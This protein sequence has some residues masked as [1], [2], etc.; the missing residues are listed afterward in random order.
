MRGKRQQRDHGGLQSSHRFR[1]QPG[2]WRGARTM[3]GSNAV[4]TQD[5]ELQLRRSWRG[6]AQGPVN[7]H[8][9]HRCLGS[10]PGLV[11]LVRLAHPGG[12]AP[13]SIREMPPRF[14]ASAQSSWCSAGISGHLRLQLITTSSSVWTRAWCSLVRL[15]RCGAH[16]LVKQALTFPGIVAVSKFQSQCTSKRFACE[17]VKLVR[18]APSN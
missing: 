7:P 4:V 8:T 18:A 6:K 15:A 2:R 5:P 16:R 10:R 1:L 17:Q 3:P 12:R 9:H 11:S 14:R 13:S